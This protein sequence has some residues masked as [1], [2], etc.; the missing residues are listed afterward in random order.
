MDA[1]LGRVAP[2]DGRGSDRALLDVR[3]R[4]SPVK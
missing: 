2:F 4:I 1:V 3:W